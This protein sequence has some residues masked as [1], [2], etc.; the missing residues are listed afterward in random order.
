[1]LTQRTLPALVRRWLVLAL[2]IGAAMAIGDASAQPVLGHARWCV[3]LADIGGGILHCKY[4][5]LEKCIF[6][7]RGLSHQCALNPWY[8]EPPQRPARKK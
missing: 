5:S 1:L 7:A 6:Y 2:L 4:D 3:N 8:E